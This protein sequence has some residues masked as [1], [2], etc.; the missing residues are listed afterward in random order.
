[1]HIERLTQV[2]TV[3]AHAPEDM[4]DM[5]NYGNPACGTPGC[6]AGFAVQLAGN[7][8]TSDSTSREAQSWLDLDIEVSRSLF[9]DQLDVTDVAELNITRPEVLGAID[10]LLA[11]AEFPTWPERVQNLLDED[12][13]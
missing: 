5:A 2:R 11:G 3:M 13:G 7:P 1:M 12:E 8:N 4:I 10:S 9:L 6:I